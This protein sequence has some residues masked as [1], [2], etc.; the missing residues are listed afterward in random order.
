MQSLLRPSAWRQKKTRAARACSGENEITTL[1]PQAQSLMS[2]INTLNDLTCTNYALVSLKKW[3][4]GRLVCIGDAAHSTTPHLG[5]G[6]N[7]ALL[8]ALAFADELNGADAIEALTRAAHFRRR[9]VM[10]CWQLSN[11][12]GPIFQNESR[13]LAMTRDRVL[14]WLPHLPWIG[15]AMVGAMAGLHTGLFS[16]LHISSKPP[17]RLTADNPRSRR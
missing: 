16:R 5:Q 1:G 17:P 6:V 8:D 3:N 14:P 7:L 2:Q 12:L 10:W 11:L 9:Q 15:R 4:A 13:L